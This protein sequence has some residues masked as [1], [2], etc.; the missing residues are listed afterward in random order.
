VGL[1]LT[2][3]K[4]ISVAEM[5]KKGYNKLYESTTIG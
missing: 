5:I 3:N 2:V 4:A 1:G